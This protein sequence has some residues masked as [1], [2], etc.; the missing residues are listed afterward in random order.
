V[1]V[2]SWREQWIS[3][4]LSELLDIAMIFHVGV[5][6]SPLHETLLTRAFD[7]SNNAAATAAAGGG[8]PGQAG[9]VAL[10][11]VAAAEINAANAAQPPG[12]G[13]RQW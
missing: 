4:A 10:G 3:F 12:Q 11:D 5:S 13:P 9:G 7:G 2:L 6:F 1:V 8:Q